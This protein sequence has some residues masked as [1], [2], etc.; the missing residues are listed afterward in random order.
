M[1]RGERKTYLIER[2][3][4]KGGNKKPALFCTN[5]LF[6]SLNKIAKK[7]LDRK[8]KYN[9][10]IIF[11]ASTLLNPCKES[12]NILKNSNDFLHTSV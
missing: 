6:L 10:S 7:N 2:G 12:E 11:F 1:D 8:F 3:D 4:R 5:S 9:Q